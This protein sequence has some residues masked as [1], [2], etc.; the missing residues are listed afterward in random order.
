MTGIESFTRNMNNFLYQDKAD[1]KKKTIEKSKKATITCLEIIIESRGK[2]AAT[3][4]CLLW[5]EFSYS[6]YCTLLAVVTYCSDCWEL[7][8]GL[9]FSRNLVLQSLMVSV[10]IL[11]SNISPCNKNTSSKLYF[12]WTISLNVLFLS[13]VF[14]NTMKP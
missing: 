10:K 4:L 6:S 11:S 13:L 14:F 1:S 12:N 8:V 7:S 2:G 9:A 3:L 5:N